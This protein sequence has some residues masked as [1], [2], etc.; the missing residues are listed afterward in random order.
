MDDKNRNKSI[1]NIWSD[2]LREKWSPIW[3]EVDSFYDGNFYPQDNTYLVCTYMLDNVSKVEIWYRTKT[4]DE[5]ILTDGTR[6]YYYKFKKNGPEYNGRTVLGS[7]N[8][9]SKRVREAIVKFYKVFSDFKDSRD[10]SLL[11][12]I[13]FYGADAEVEFVCINNEG[14]IEIWSQSDDGIWTI[15]VDDFKNKSTLGPKESGRDILGPL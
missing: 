15:S 3:D 11:S 9:T 10:F 14:Y 7:F 4:T 1:W 13:K 6:K 12:A 5:W 8:D 2:L